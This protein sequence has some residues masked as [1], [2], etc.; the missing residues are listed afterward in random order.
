MAPGE[1]QANSRKNTTVNTTVFFAAEGGNSGQEEA[2]RGGD[3]P[4]AMGRLVSEEF[5]GFREPG[6]SC[7][8]MHHILHRSLAE[9]EGEGMM[10]NRWGGPAGGECCGGR[11]RPHPQLRLARRQC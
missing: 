2:V 4:Q 9:G 5:S 8:K 3:A 6:T 1:D 10:L 11:K 7:E